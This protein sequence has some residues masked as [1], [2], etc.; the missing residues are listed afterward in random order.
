[1][2]TGTSETSCGSGWVPKPMRAK[3]EVSTAVRLRMPRKMSMRGHMFKVAVTVTLPSVVLVTR[4]PKAVELSVLRG[5]T[6]RAEGQGSALG[7]GAG[8]ELMPGSG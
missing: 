8:S 5:V 6:G 2:S 7:A 4:P 1:M 3:G